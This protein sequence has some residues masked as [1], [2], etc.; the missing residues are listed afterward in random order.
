MRLF[1]LWLSAISIFACQKPSD[2][3]PEDTTQSSANALD[4]VTGVIL[5]DYDGATRGQVGNPNVKVGS[6]LLYPNPAQGQIAV[7][8]DVAIIKIWLVKAAMD[9][10]FRNENFMARFRQFDYPEPELDKKSLRMMTVMR[11]Q[12]LALRLTDFPAGYYRVVYKL[13]NGALHWDN[14]YIHEEDSYEKAVKKLFHD[15]Q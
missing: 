8:S 11:A 5:R 13:G 12:N 15:W 2:A 3:T 10:N 6:T 1:I 7:S 9:K 4:I 14:L